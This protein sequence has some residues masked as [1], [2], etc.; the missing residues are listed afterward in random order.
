[1]LSLKSFIP[2]TNLAPE[3]SPTSQTSAFNTEKALRN[4]SYNLY[5]VLVHLGN[6]SHSGHYY[7]YIK[8]PNNVWY[9]ADDQRIS[10]VQSRDALGQNAYILFYN[11]ISSPDKTTSLS[12]PANSN[13]IIIQPKHIPQII[14][15]DSTTTPIQRMNSVVSTSTYLNSLNNTTTA[16]TTA[17]F[18]ASTSQEVPKI[19]IKLKKPE[20]TSPPVYGPQLPPHL[21]S[22]SSSSSSSINSNLTIKEKSQKL[23]EQLLKLTDLKKIKKKLKKFNLKKLKRLKQNID[24][25]QAG[26]SDTHKHR[27]KRL[28]IKEKRKQLQKKDGQKKKLSPKPSCHNH[29]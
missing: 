14:K 2:E 15:S 1:M 25:A 28:L 29:H 23:L 6:T 18:A 17:T 16:A 26:D 11:R 7:S 21:A 5:G 12:P 27:L 4:V 10:T 13:S 19:V 9:K 3:S 8:G 24:E 20:T 22:P